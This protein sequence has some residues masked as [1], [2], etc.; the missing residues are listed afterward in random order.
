MAKIIKEEREHYDDLGRNNDT[1][2]E[3]MQNTM[4]EAHDSIQLINNLMKEA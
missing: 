1:T 3:S 4:K 2:C